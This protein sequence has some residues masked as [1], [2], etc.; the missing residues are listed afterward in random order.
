MEDLAKAVVELGMPLLKEV[1]IAIL[2]DVPL[3]GAGAAIDLL[4][5]GNV[6]MHALRQTLVSLK[7]S[8]IDADWLFLASLG[9]L[10]DLQTVQEAVTRAA[11]ETAEQAA[12]HGFQCLGV[13][14]FGGNVLPETEQIAKRWCVVSGRSPAFRTAPF[15]CGMKPMRIASP[16]YAKFWAKIP[17][18]S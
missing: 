13:V 17:L 3:G 5:G 7:D 12:R 10:R 6:L 18:S 8:L 14:T 4:T 1:A 9:R 16:P 2:E 11:E 15:Y